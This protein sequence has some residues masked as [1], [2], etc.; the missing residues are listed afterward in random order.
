METQALVLASY[1]LGA[2]VGLAA[3]V[4]LLDKIRA[5]EKTARRLPARPVVD[6]ERIAPVAIVPPVK[7]HFSRMSTPVNRSKYEWRWGT[8]I[9]TDGKYKNGWTFGPTLH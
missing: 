9:G 6:V 3:I 8:G 2:G 7:T 4:V 5:G 1:V